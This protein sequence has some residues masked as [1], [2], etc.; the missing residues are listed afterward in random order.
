[1]GSPRRKF[2]K[3]YDKYVNKIYRFIY[4][5]VDSQE[6]AEDLTSQVFTK[7]WRR[8]KQNQDIKNPSAYLYQVARAEIADYYGKRP[9]FQIVSTETNPIV[10]S[11][12]TDS[13]PSAEE[14]LGLQ[15]DIETM[16]GALAKL[17][18]D[19]QNIIIWRYLDGYS[20]KEIARLMEKPEGTVRVM[21]HRALKEL[22]E[23]MENN[24]QESN[25]NTTRP[26]SS[27]S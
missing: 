18:E 22:K 15:S 13:Q 9:N 3:I 6:T 21:L 5:K 16:K 8:F 10:N 24:T 17:D 12:L 14:N 23:K 7:G 27:R 4:L 20:N 26:L 2:A 25:Q 11:Q 1:M 19:E